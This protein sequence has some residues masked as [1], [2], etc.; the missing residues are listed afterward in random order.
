MIDR[1]ATRR[2]MSHRRAEARAEVRLYVLRLRTARKWGDPDIEASRLRDLRNA[3]L[4][5]RA[6]LRR[7]S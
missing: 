4:R 7:A 6:L 3:L 1:E 5:C 2:Y